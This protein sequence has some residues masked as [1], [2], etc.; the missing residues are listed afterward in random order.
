MEIF[1]RDKYQSRWVGGGSGFT[2]LFWQQAGDDHE[3]SHNQQDDR[4]I[5]LEV[6]PQGKSQDGANQKTDGGILCPVS[7]KGG[8]AQP[9]QSEWNTHAQQ[10]YT[11]QDAIPE[12]GVP[13]NEHGNNHHDPNGGEDAGRD[14]RPPAFLPAEIHDVKGQGKQE[15]RNRTGNV[16]ADEQGEQGEGADDGNDGGG[17]ERPAAGAVKQVNDQERQ[18]HGIHEQGTDQV[19]ADMLREQGD[20][21]KDA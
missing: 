13:G 5:I 6:A 4:P 9:E 3:D 20:Q 17:D 7:G 19:A 11:G 10:G 16:P 8:P 21:P 1:G 14:E 18:R 15:H 12:G 2:G